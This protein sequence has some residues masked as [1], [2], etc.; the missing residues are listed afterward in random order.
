MKRKKSQMS[1]PIKSGLYN[2]R[3]FIIATMIGGPLV[4]GFIL[5]LNLWA[6][7]R[8][9]LTII[10]VVLG[11]LFDFL[12]IIIVFF[13]TRHIRAF[14]LRNILAIIFL[15]LLQ[16]VFAFL[17]KL[18]FK[19]KPEAN[20]LIFSGIESSSFHP[21]KLFPLIAISFIF[22]ITDMVFPFYSWVFLA[23]FLIPHFYIYIRVYNLFHNHK[24][25]KILLSAIVFLGCLIPLVYSSGEISFVL[26][27]RGSLF[28]TYLNYM[29]GFYVMFM[30]YFL[31][32]IIVQQLL[33]SFNKLIHIVPNY[34]IRNRK[35]ISIN[36][37]FI[38][39]CAVLITAYGFYV[40]NNLIVRSYNVTIQK[41]SSTLDS[42]KVVCIADLHLKEMTSETFLRG[43]TEKI[44]NLKP[45]IIVI[46]GDVLELYGHD[47]PE[48]LNTY[49][50]ILLNLETTY[51]IYIT[52][53]NHD[54]QNKMKESFGFYDHSKTMVLKDSLI[55]VNGKFYV[56]GLNYRGN[57]QKRPIDSILQSKAKDLPVILL[58][59]A[60]YCLEEAISNGIDIQFSG[61]THNGQIFPFNYIT[62]SLF[63]NSWGYS[64]YDKTN[65]FVTCGVQDAL[66]PS[67]QDVSIPVRIG[68]ISEILEIDIEL[69]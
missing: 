5:A 34:Y 53:G 59:H 52:N 68:S 19:K 69:K 41:Q 64:K 60:P 42:L 32:F 47:N 45:D 44:N 22:F 46:P 24:I 1:E 7:Q 67:R 20:K 66:L 21:R 62:S 15:F 16:C 13:S 26:M 14:A 65:L 27:G 50:N 37:T 4:S 25:A 61:H 43:L 8:K 63:E 9:L 3:Q 58:D 2:I 6:K 11:L 54:F 48:T 12:L 39:L 28:Y 33:K 30:L 18:Q 40:N 49:S 23:I 55:E 51:G 10:P 31:F 38:V 57:H 36:L 56:L 17:I 35:I 29:I